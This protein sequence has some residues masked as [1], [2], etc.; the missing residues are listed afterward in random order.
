M[1]FLEKDAGRFTEL[2]GFKPLVFPR[3]TFRESGV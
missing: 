2:Q 1:E 3:E